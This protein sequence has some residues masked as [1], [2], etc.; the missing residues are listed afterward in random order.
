MQ[1]LDNGLMR[2]YVS[3]AELGQIVKYLECQT[4]SLGF[5]HERQIAVISCSN[6]NWLWGGKRNKT[7]ALAS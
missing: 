3:E 5:Y 2:N 6:S 7:W 4:Q 1:Y